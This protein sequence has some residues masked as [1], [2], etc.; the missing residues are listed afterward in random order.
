VP[1]QAFVLRSLTPQQRQYVL[2]ILSLAPV[3]LRPAFVT[4]PTAVPGAARRSAVQPAR[5]SAPT[6]ASVA[7]SLT[8]RERRYVMGILSLTP[9][10]LRAAFG[11][12]P[13][14]APGA[15]SD[16][17]AST[18]TTSSSVVLPILPECGPGAVLARSD[19][20]GAG[21][22]SPHVRSARSGRAGCAARTRYLGPGRRVAPKRP[23]GHDVSVT[24]QVASRKERER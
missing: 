16:A 11:T 2:G 22:Q 20:H 9:V 23:S 17:P 24:R 21:G 14:V 10:Q 6:M 3:Q 15:G 5:P 12:R 13:A 19:R 18:G 1:T 8:P 7:R 4:S